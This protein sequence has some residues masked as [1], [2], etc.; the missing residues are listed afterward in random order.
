VRREIWPSSNGGVVLRIKD[1]NVYSVAIYWYY[2]LIR[3]RDTEGQGSGDQGQ[4][5]C[6]NSTAADWVC[7][8]TACEF[9]M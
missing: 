8:K 3:V 2:G 7:G 1:K 5:R 6:G 9:L 4:E